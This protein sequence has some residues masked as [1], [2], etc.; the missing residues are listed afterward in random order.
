MRKMHPPNR[1][2]ADWVGLLPFQDT[3]NAPTKQRKSKLGGR[4][5]GKTSRAAG[6]TSRA[7]GKK[8]QNIPQNPTPIFFCMKNYGKIQKNKGE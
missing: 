6:K 2:K 1:R 8:L 7:A 4:A 5:T 3:E